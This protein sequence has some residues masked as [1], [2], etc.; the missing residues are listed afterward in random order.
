VNPGDVL[1]VP[2]GVVHA[3]YTT[4]YTTGPVSIHLSLGLYKHRVTWTHFLA[5]LLQLSNPKHH[6]TAQ[7]FRA[8]TDGQE[9]SPALRLSQ[10]LSSKVR[11]FFINYIVIT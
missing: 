3:P 2:Q 7:Q 11:F 4:G 6:A 5:S 10:K 1:Y 9:S 8:E